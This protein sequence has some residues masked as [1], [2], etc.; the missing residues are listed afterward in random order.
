MDKHRGLLSLVSPSDHVLSQLVVNPC[1]WSIAN[2]ALYDWELVRGRV[3]IS[4]RIESQ[5]RNIIGQAE[6]RR[7]SVSSVCHPC[8][9]P[10]ELEHGGKPGEAFMCGHSDTHGIPGHDGFERRLPVARP[11]QS[12]HAIHVE[13]AKRTLRPRRQIGLHCR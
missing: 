10:H 12:D 6:H 4:V 11:E 5:E 8:G 9:G 3:S 2:E 7:E 1:Y 13:Q